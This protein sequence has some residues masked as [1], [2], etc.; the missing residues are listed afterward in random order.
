MCALVFTSVPDQ[1]NFV[2]AIDLYDHI[3]FVRKIY[4]INPGVQVFNS[5][6]NFKRLMVG[7]RY[8]LKNFLVDI[9]FDGLKNNLQ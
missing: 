9:N 4:N 6:I 5:E 1:L 7:G 2:T 3:N 8:C